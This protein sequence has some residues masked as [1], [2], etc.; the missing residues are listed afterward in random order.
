LP[1]GFGFAYS[2]IA[3]LNSTQSYSAAVNNTTIA[4]SKLAA[5]VSLAMKL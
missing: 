2:G 5:L 4:P 1:K 3:T